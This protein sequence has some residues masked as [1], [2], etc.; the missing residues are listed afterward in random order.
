MWQQAVTPQAD[1]HATALHSAPTT[2]QKQ[3]DAVSFYI[4]L[5]FPIISMFAFP[6]F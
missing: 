4:A 2:G 1:L 5:P 6:L 3:P